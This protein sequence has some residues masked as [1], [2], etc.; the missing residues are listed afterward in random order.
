MI[1]S[2]ESVKELSFE[3]THVQFKNKAG[4]WRISLRQLA[5]YYDIPF[6]TASQKLTH[7]SELFRDL[8]AGSVTLPANGS[9]FDYDLSIR[10]ADIT[11]TFLY[12]HTIVYYYEDNRKGM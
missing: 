4:A 2:F 11:N 12:S 5:D 3:D 10:D 8:G 9:A 7:N 1:D 6:K